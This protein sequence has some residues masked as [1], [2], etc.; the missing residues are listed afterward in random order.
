M[1]G[2]SVPATPLSRALEADVSP[3]QSSSQVPGPPTPPLVPGHLGA[4]SYGKC[5]RMLVVLSAYE[6]LGIELPDRLA[7]Q[8]AP[9]R[10]RLVE[11]GRHEDLDRIMEAA[12]VD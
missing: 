7:W 11:W 9:W 6:T 4:P 2:A 12:G 3:S 5:A 8:I 1:A 10:D